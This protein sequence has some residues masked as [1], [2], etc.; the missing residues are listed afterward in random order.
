MEREATSRMQPRDGGWPD[1]VD[2]ILEGDC[3]VMFAYVTP[4]SGVV[5]TPMTNF[6]VRDRAAGT[7][8]AVNT[9]S[10]SGRSSR[11]SVEILG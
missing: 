10:G 6:A 9:P 5:L 4:A 7:L 8:T 2:E 11:G 1:P 3:V